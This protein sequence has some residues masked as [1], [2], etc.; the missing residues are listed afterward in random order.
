MAKEKKWEEFTATYKDADGDEHEASITVHVVTEDTKGEVSV[1]GGG[2]VHTQPGNVLC[3]TSTA[4]VYD[5][6]T[7][8]QWN[9]SGYASSKKSDETAK[10][11]R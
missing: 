4:N 8:E 3:P 10:T 7:Q 5:V 6:L 2:I 1:I 9:S 11:R